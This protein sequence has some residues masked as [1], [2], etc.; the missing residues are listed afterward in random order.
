M[1]AATTEPGPPR[2]EYTPDWSLRTP[3]LTTSAEICEPAT[4]TPT[5]ADRSKPR[6]TVK[7]NGRT[8]LPL[9]ETPRTL[10]V[11]P[12]RRSSKHYGV[13]G[14]CVNCFVLPIDSRARPA[15]RFGAI[16]EGA[17]RATTSRPAGLPRPSRLRRAGA[18]FACPGAAAAD[19]AAGGGGAFARAPRAHRRGVPQGHR[20][21]ETAR[22]R[23]HD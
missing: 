7:R 23:H 12:I 2:S 11:Q 9:P 16:L 21:G 15:G 3:I 6:A 13:A 1:R 17:H 19:R 14:N 5:A 18:G 22:R 8:T 20:R 4:A 10:H